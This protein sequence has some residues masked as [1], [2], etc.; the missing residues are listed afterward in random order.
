[1]EE[2]LRKE[3]IIIITNVSTGII[4]KCPVSEY[5]I[6]NLKTMKKEKQEKHLVIFLV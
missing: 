6:T 5:K 3:K 1:M 4:A 2:G